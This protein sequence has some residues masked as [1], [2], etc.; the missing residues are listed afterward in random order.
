ME[1]DVILIIFFY[2]ILKQNQSMLLMEMDFIIIIF[3]YLIRQ[4]TLLYKKKV[5]QV[6]LMQQKFKKILKKVLKKYIIFMEINFISIKHF[7]QI[8]IEKFKTNKY[9]RVA[10][11]R[12][13]FFMLINFISIIYL[14]LINKYEQQYLF[15]MEIDFIH[16]FVQQNLIFLEKSQMSMVINYNTMIQIFEDFIANLI[17]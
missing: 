12:S 1:M 9:L 7:H 15:F 17:I 13:L 16:I 2:L 6:S 5:R 4:V 14:I 3:F 10:L 8:I 11:Q